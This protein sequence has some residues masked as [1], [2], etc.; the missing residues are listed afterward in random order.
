M[1]LAW[2]AAVAAF[3]MAFPALLATKAAAEMTGQAMIL[4]VDP[5]PL[6]VETETGERRFTV[7]I[8]DDGYQRAAGLMFRTWMRDDHGMLFV[9]ERMKHLSFWMKNTPMPLDLLFADKSGRIIAIMA[10]EPFS[11]APIAPAAPGQFVLE[12]KAGTAQKAGIAAGDR[13]RHPRIEAAAGAP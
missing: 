2:I 8:A 12:L 11:L 9:F 4:P 7:E 6:V 10:G 13:M 5:D 3:S 1:R